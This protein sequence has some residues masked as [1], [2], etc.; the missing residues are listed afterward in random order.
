MAEFVEKGDDSNLLTKDILNIIL[1]NERPINNE[2]HR[3]LQKFQTIFEDGLSNINLSWV[4][5]LTQ[6]QIQM[7]FQLQKLRFRR[8]VS[9]EARKRF[10]QGYQVYQES[11]TLLKSKSRMIKISYAWRRFKLNLHALIQRETNGC[12]R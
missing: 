3:I 7:R 6:L 9:Q 2:D 12:R 10:S 4:L 8:S 5:M 1:N 11:T